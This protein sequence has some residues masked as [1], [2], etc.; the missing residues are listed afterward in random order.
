MKIPQKITSAWLKRRGFQVVE[1]YR[2]GFRTALLKTA[3]WKWAHLTTIAEGRNY[4][5]PKDD[6][7]HVTPC[8]LVNGH[9]KVDRKNKGVL[10]V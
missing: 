7:R 10:N 4:R 9:W 3:G 6:L 2:F 1:V 5:I 8:V